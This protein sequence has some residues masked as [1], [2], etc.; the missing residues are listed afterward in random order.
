M[1]CVPMIDYNIQCVLN[2]HSAVYYNMDRVIAIDYCRSCVI[3]L[4]IN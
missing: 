3:L 2:V 4:Q 1:N